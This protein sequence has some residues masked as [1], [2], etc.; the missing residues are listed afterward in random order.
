M[1]CVM[2]C[3]IGRAISIYLGDAIGGAFIRCYQAL[4]DRCARAP[5]RIIPFHNPIHAAVAAAVIS[6]VQQ[7]ASGYGYQRALSARMDATQNAANALQ[8]SD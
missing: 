7:N 2:G 1:G 5:S 8:I 6:R 4:S 3:V